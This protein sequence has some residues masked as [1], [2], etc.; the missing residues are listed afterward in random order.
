MGNAIKYTPPE[1]QVGVFLERVDQELR[2]VVRDTGIGI[3]EEDQAHLFEEFF[4]AENAKSIEREGTG[5]G[6]S[7][8]K[9]LVDRYGGRI[10]VQSAVNE[11][12]TFTVSLPMQI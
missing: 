12:T 6:L 10:G 7:I 5:L 8:V 3:P 9:S 4:R 2:L 1:G 11:G